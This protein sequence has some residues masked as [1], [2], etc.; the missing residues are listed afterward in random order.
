[1]ENMFSISLGKHC[2]EKG[3]QLAFFDHQ[4]VQCKFSFLVPSLHQQLVLETQF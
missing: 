3:K 2:D 1:M 4:D